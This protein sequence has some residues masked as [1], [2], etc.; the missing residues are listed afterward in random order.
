MQVIV[1]TSKGLTDWNENVKFEKPFHPSNT[2]LYHYPLQPKVPSF[3]QPSAKD[4]LFTLVSENYF[5]ILV[6][7]VKQAI[8][9]RP[10]FPDELTFFRNAM[11]LFQRGNYQ[12]KCNFRIS[13]PKT[14]L[15]LKLTRH[16]EF[17]NW[18]CFRLE[19]ANKH[20]K[21]S[22]KQK[23]LVRFS[24]IIR[25]WT[26]ICRSREGERERRLDGPTR[27][28]AKKI[29]LID[30]LSLILNKRHIRHKELNDKWLN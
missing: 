24:Q 29:N 14:K 11:T 3:N 4:Y 10:Y 6:V 8:N 27:K 22:I 13:I 1:L 16:Q 28:K 19:C 23:V 17:V 20:G 5:Y 2:S 15:N 26:I 30:L 7:S 18:K 21:K 9:R 25:S 12:R